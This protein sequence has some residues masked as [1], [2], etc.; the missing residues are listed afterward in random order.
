MRTSY[1]VI[2]CHG[3]SV[4]LVES[5]LGRLD[6]KRIAIQC[7]LLGGGD[8][9]TNITIKQIAI[10]GIRK[11]GRDVND[12]QPMQKGFCAV[13]IIVAAQRGAAHSSASQYM[14]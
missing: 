13:Q 5:R 7:I 4:K 10:P 8:F 1:R 3:R 6:V 2:D 11:K 14:M 9:Y 12:T